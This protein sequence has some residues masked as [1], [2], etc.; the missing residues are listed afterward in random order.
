MT[1]ASL[2]EQGNEK[3]KEKSYLATLSLYSKALA[4][5][6]Q[7]YEAYG[8]RAACLVR[9]KKPEKTLEDAHRAVDINPLF[10]K[11][12]IR[13]AEVC[14]CVCDRVCVCVC[15]YAMHMLV[16]GCRSMHT[17][18][19]HTLMCRGHSVMCNAAWGGMW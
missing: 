5:D 3:F 12:Y 18:P 19:S 10:V 9:L 4:A 14:V 13:R 11:A 8:N 17:C 15:M 16:C 1:E 7:D 6:P 2:R